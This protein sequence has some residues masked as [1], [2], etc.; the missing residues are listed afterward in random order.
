MNL[1]KKK[2][3]CVIISTTKKTSN[4]QPPKNPEN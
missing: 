4:P 1:G 2:K 3:I